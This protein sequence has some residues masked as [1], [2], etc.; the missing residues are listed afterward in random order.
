MIEGPKGKAIPAQKVTQLYVMGDD[1]KLQTVRIAINPRGYE[2]GGPF[3]VSHFQTCP[4]AS[5][6]SRKKGS[7]DA[8]AQGDQRQDPASQRDR[9]DRGGTS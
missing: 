3:Y 8:S 9:D 1:G 4:Y 7:G 5:S 6:F 2:V